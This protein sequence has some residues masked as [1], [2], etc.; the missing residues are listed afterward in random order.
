MFTDRSPH[1]P[2]WKGAFIWR[3]ILSLAETQHEVLVAT[4]LALVDIP[5]SHPRLNIIRPINSWRLDQLPKLIKVIFGHRPDVLHTFA[6]QQS[7]LWPSLSVW[8]FLTMI[9]AKKRVATLFEEQ[10]CH[11]DFAAFEWYKNSGRL[12]VFGN[13]HRHTLGKVFARSLDSLPLDLEIPPMDEGP[14]A[15]HAQF[16]LVPAAVDQWLEVRQGFVQLAEW[17]R[18]NPERE[19]RIVGGWGTYPASARKEIWRSLG[20]LGSQIHMCE[21]MSLFKFL[22]VLREAH[23]LGLT[24]VNP[25]SWKFL[26]SYQLGRQLGKPVL[27][28]DESSPELAVGSTANSL[29]RLYAGL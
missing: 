28:R 5:F 19:V 3:T 6:L 2:E 24:A 10:D 4:P 27:T 9:P 11:E 26:L 16:L 18:Q 21:D 17:L 1:D 13:S 25:S 20:K 22:D 14:I 23:T 12:T 29:S 7:R 15:S 8:P